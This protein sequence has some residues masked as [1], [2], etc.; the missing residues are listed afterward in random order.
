MPL[1]KRL[2]QIAG[3]L[4]LA[5]ALFQVVLGISPAL[6]TY[7]GAPPEL[8][9]NP[10][11]LLASSL[12]VALIFAIW[13]LYGL[14][15]AGLIRRLPLLRLGLLVIGAIYTLRGLLLIPLL[16]ASLGLLAAP[17]P[18]LP[19]ALLASLVSLLIGCLYLAGAL[20]SWRDLRPETPSP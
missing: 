8:L 14:S 18:I 17:E 19:Q 6:S 15:G 20:A 11:A 10:A 12:I 2:L 13:G 9:A 5:V 1:S 16:L 3:L 7:F 4:S